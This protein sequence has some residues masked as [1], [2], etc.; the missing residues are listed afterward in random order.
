MILL[1]PVQGPW[2][3]SL[4]QVSFGH[5]VFQAI[6]SFRKESSSGISIWTAA[7]LCMYS[8]SNL[9]QLYLFI[10]RRLIISPYLVQGQGSVVR[11]QYP[12]HSEVDLVRSL[13]F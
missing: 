5:F 12:K 3:S 8:I 2:A 9:Y 13:E 11:A 4:F 7:A 6:D 1:C 10:E